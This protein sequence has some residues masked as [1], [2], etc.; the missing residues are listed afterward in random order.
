MLSIF[1]GLLFFHKS[2]PSAGPECNAAGLITKSAGCA[3]E[4]GMH[5][6]H[7][8]YI[9]VNTWIGGDLYP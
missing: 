7:C 3:W 1:H 2:R 5:M 6:A 9:R 8:V 4:M